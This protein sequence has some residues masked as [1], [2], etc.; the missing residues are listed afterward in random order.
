MSRQTIL[1]VATSQNGTK[2]DPANSNRTKYGAWYGINGQPWCAI[3]VSWVYNQAGHPLGTIDSPKGYHYCPSA[4]NFWKAH[5]CLTASPQ[6]GD[7][8]LFD[9][10]GDGSADHTGIFVKW[11]S[12]G[13]TFQTWE[14]NTAVGNDSDGGQVMMRTRSVGVV[15]AF[16]NPGIFN[17]KINDQKT[18]WKTGDSGAEVTRIQKMLYDL[19][20]D[21]VVDGKFGN[22]T[23]RIVKQ[24]QKAKGIAVTG[25]VDAITEGALEHD[26]TK[27]NVP[28]AK[29]TT[30]SYLT[31]GSTG[32]AV[33]A[34]QKALNKKGASP[35]V[36][37]DGVF[38]A[39]TVAAL[40]KFQSDN[41]L[42]V[43]GVAGPMTLKA[44]GIR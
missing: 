22:G 10:N 40:K 42:Q 16:V 21:I 15:K 34:L 3:F 9:W 14:G 28:D 39:D 2:E 43:D 30:G 1:T 8:V 23:Q 11:I 33:I 5:N 7:I 36:A 19:G 20:Y 24:F 6:P 37:E 38:G 27:P 26:L 44:L 17:D 12:A 32:A 13:K 25:I 29:T 4:F 41:S 18:E 35:A 31:K